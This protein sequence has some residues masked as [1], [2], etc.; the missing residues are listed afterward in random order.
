MEPIAQDDELSI[1]WATIG[2]SVGVAL[3]SVALWTVELPFRHAVRTARGTHRTR[4][5]VLVHLIGHVPASDGGSVSAVEG[6]GECA[7]LAD[8]TF[9][10]EDTERSLAVLRHVLVPTLAAVSSDSDG[11]GNRLPPP[12]ELEEIRQASPH[13]PLAFSALEMA[14]ADIHLR[15]EG[16]SLAA[17]LGVEGR[18]VEIGAVVGQ[19]DTSDQLVKA[20]GALVG[21]GYRR[22]KLKIGPRWDVEPVSRVVSAFP[23]LLV[24]ADAN[25][26]YHSIDESE[27]AEAAHRTGPADRPEPP[28]PT[29]PGRSGPTALAELGSRNDLPEL[30]A[31]DR[32]G[33]LCLEQPFERSDLASHAYLARRMDTPICLDESLDSPRTVEEALSTGA[34][35]VVCVKPSR[36]GGLGATLQVID[37]CRS[38]G[39]PMWIGGMFESG[40][41]RGILTTLGALDGM[42]WP[43]D[44]SPARSYLEDDLVPDRAPSRDN[45]N[46]PLVTSLPPGPG[47]GPPPDA[48]ALARVGTRHQVVSGTGR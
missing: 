4:P 26:T 39:V 14:V 20:V 15:S 31:L 40:Y 16:R 23:E 37:R 35:S 13:A 11:H 5:I 47:M 21:Q 32:F 8:A 19:T 43:G 2:R 46:G 27:L 44:L 34:C 12:S 33:L 41:G 29:H 1:W 42:A 18:Q 10:A 48:D 9:D 45:G 38:G 17:V 25:G 30:L 22:V 24:Q 3:D 7:A 36:L 28:V 6:W